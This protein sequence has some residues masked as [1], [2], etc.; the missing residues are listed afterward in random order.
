MEGT[1]EVVLE[2]ARVYY[3]ERSLDIQGRQELRG[4]AGQ[5]KGCFRTRDHTVEPKQL[6]KTGGL[7]TGEA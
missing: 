6:R 3:C 2:A 4:M 1:G 5:K 7:K